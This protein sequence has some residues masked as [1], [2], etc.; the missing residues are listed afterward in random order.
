MY[1]HLSAHHGDCV[2]VVY[3]N[4]RPGKIDPIP[5]AATAR[6]ASPRPS[7]SRADRKWWLIGPARQPKLKG[8]V[9]VADGVV[10]RVRAIQPGAAWHYDDRG[11]A[12]V[13]L[14]APLTDAQFP[15]LGIRPVDARPARTGEDPRVPGPVTRRPRPCG[16]PIGL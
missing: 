14:T 15:T 4:T 7:S 1:R 6:Q 13:P 8:F 16:R 11:Y 5:A 10:S 2:M 12:D 3:R 9:Y